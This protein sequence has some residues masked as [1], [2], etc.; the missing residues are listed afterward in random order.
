[1]LEAGVTEFVDDVQFKSIL[2]D[3][4]EKPVGTVDK[5]ELLNYCPTYN[6]WFT[7]WGSSTLVGVLWMN[8][9]NILQ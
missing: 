6:L 5:N 1:M 9:I 8:R 7:T 2:V 4:Q 3:S